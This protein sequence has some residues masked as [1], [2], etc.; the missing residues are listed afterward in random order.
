MKELNQ[1]LHLDK[2]TFSVMDPQKRLLVE[3][4]VKAIE[5]RKSEIKSGLIFILELE[6]VFPGLLMVS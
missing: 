1:R 5:E 6:G 3:S 4:F 2:K